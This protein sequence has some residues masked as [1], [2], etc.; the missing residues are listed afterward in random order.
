MPNDINCFLELGLPAP[1]DILL[2]VILDSIAL[3][4]QRPISIKLSCRR[5]V[6]LLV[7]TCVCTCVGLSSGVWKNG[8]SDAEGVLLG[9]NFW[10]TIVTNGDVTAYMCDSAAARPSSLI[11]LGKLVIITKVVKHTDYESSS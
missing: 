9:A 7:D 8:G 3:V 2:L 5:S 6:G 4:A 1:G 10:C 11:T